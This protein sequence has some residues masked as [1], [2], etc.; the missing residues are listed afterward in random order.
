VC[1]LGKETGRDWKEDEARKQVIKVPTSVEPLSWGRFG[2]V[3][4]AGTFG[5]SR[6]PQR[7]SPV[8]NDGR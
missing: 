7:I 5:M 4:V 8:V 2:A 3:E 1:V 6:G